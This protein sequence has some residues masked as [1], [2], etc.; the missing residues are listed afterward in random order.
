MILLLNLNQY[1]KKK[2]F[3]NEKVTSF[4]FDNIRM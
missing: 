4:D 1:S 3:Q 2:L